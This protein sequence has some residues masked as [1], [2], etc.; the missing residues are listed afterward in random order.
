ME[1]NKDII[2][3]TE[4]PVALSST[5]RLDHIHQEFNRSGSVHDFTDGSVF[6]N[7][8]RG[9]FP[10]KNTLLDLGTAT[11]TV[12]QTMCMSGMEAIGLEGSEAAKDRRLGA[13]GVCPQ[14]L[15]TCDIGE[16]F[17]ITK[18]DGASVVFDFVTSW[19]VM[20][21][22]PEAGLRQCLKNIDAHLAIDGIGILNI[23]LAY[24]PDDDFHMLWTNFEGDDAAKIAYLRSII[25]EYFDIDQ[26]LENQK[27]TYCRPTQGEREGL[28]QKQLPE[29]FDRTYWW[30][31]P[32]R[33]QEMIDV[34]KNF[35]TV[36]DNRPGSHATL[37]AADGRKLAF[38]SDA[39][40]F[41][42]GMKQYRW[43]FERPIGLDGTFVFATADREIEF[44][45]EGLNGTT[46]SISNFRV[47]RL[48]D[49]KPVA[50]VKR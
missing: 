48:G 14:I 38:R 45:V 13:W 5:D 9:R 17:R 30:I 46:A 28:R 29:D 41:N 32:R 20:E 35:L 24:N 49:G 42:D 47:D 27:W 50:L 23:D 18:P 43:A 7:E 1:F 44:V 39:S 21:H 19:G 2:L 34:T 3:Q 8:L 15:S 12:P 31:R 26:S 6:A 37:F 4:H 16:P 22:L 33:R 40:V 11:G 36:C 10:G 25:E